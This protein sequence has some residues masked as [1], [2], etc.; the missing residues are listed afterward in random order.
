MYTKKLLL[1]ALFVGLIASSCS[2]SY[3]TNS[4]NVSKE[5]NSYDKILVVGRA[6]EMTRRIEFENQMVSA[7]KA[8]GVNAVA[9]YDVEYTR[10]IDKQ[11]SDAQMEQL[12]KNL[13]KEGFDGAIVTSLVDTE[14]YKD[15]IPGGTS[16]TYVPA[17]VGRFGRYYT[18]YPI[19]TWEPDEIRTGVLYI[20]ESSLFQ[21]GGSKEQNLQWVG[22]FE[23]RNPSSLEKTAENYAT[24][25]VAELVAKSISK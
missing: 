25:L 2:S 23:I 21:L 8:Q 9:S 7:F 6:K 18:Y 20:L 16:T 22:R 11:L 4:T 10:L 13:R 24:E 12:E 19:Q 1:V 3:L 14:K 15:I 5:K 17:R